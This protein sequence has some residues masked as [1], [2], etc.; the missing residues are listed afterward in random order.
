MSN[1]YL[2][3]LCANCTDKTDCP[4]VT[5]IARGITE[6]KVMFDHGSGARYRYDVP[7]DVCGAFKPRKVD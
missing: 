4:R 5:C 7:Y 3:D 1:Y 2:C 6:K